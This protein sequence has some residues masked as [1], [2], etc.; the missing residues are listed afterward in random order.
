MLKI[1][2]VHYQRYQT[3]VEAKR[4]IF[5]YIEVFYNR[6][7]LHFANNHWTTKCS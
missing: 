2:R 3:R 5:E 1:E 7:R 4:D 6:D